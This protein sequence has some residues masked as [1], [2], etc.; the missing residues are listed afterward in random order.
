MIGPVRIAWLAL[1]ATLAAVEVRAEEPK[2]LS[3]WAES[4]SQRIAPR[5][6]VPT[7]PVTDAPRA[8]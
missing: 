4:S 8:R 2:S 6:T 3:A 5:V 1:L 7:E